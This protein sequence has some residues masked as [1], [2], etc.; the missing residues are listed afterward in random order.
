MAEEQELEVTAPFAGVVVAIPHGSRTRVGEGT[1]V[2]VLEAMKMEHD[3][4]AGAEGV[5]AGL[6]VAVGDA[7]EEGQLLL[8]LA[9]G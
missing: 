8:T 2:V 6:A 4:L 7:V 9:P 5:V 1:A 3:V